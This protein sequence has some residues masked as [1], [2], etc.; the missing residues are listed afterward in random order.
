MGE[1]LAMAQQ[2]VQQGTDTLVATPH[3]G[4]SL[5]TPPTPDVIKERVARL[6]AELDWARI[7]LKIVPGLEIKIGPNVAQDLQE[8]TLGTLGEG[9]RWALIEMPFGHIPADAFKQFQEVRDAGYKIVMA[10]PER[11]SEIQ[12]SRSFLQDCADFGMAFQLT[13]G[14]LLGRFGDRAQ[15]TAE[16]ILRRV[17]DWPLVIASDTH[18]LRDRSPAL[19]RAARDAAAVIVGAEMAQDMV[20]SRPR[21]MISSNL[22]K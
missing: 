9:S 20:D 16:S 5:R 17:D 11:Y 3:R 8:G 1:A 15:I 6:Q 21:S 22:L 4:W 2:A 12:K 19:L 10:H 18:D 7:P 13:S 14:S